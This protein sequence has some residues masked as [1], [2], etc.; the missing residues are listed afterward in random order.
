MNSVME[1]PAANLPRP[2]AWPRFCV[3]LAAPP[4]L[5]FVLSTIITI[6]LSG[7]IE[8]IK[9][10]LDGNALRTI[11][12]ARLA[13]EID[14]GGELPT[15]A[16][17]DEHALAAYLARLGLDDAKSWFSVFD[18]LRGTGEMSKSILVSAASGAER[19]I[20]PDF[21]RRPLA[22]AVALV[23][24]ISKLP[25]RTPV[26]WTRGL[27]SDGRWRAD[28]LYPEKG[29][30]VVFADGHV[31][32]F[33]KL[34]DGEFFKWGSSE[35]TSNVAEAL[36]PGT[37]IGETNPGSDHAVVSLWQNWLDWV[38]GLAWLLGGVSL[39]YVTCRSSINPQCSSLAREL[40]TLVSVACTIAAYA[41]LFRLF[42][43]VNGY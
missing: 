28:S 21:Q 32:R 23:P 11:V 27:R 18:P 12:Q 6:D 13:A 30:H 38:D 7:V 8:G 36:P 9:R 26:A 22:W 43:I 33:R 2:S 4:V 37:R 10:A 42:G 20:N 17:A 40:S 24:S 3:F 5:L 19:S 14:R 35:R 29:G 1:T 39:L 15:E 31:V 25:P 41:G 34:A 16:L